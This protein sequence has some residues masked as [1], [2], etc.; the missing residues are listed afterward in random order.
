MK[1][2]TLQWMQKNRTAA[3]HDTPTTPSMLHNG[4]PNLFATATKYGWSPFE[5]SPQAMRYMWHTDSIT[6]KASKTS[7]TIK[8]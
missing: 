1:I 7:H 6:E 8:H 3:T 4:T 5:T 2:K